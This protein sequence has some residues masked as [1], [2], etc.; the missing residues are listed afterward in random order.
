[1][2]NSNADSVASAIATASAR[3]AE[4]DMHYC[5]EKDGVLIDID[6]PDSLVA[7]ITP[8]K[9]NALKADGIINKGMIPKID[10]AFSAVSNG[11]KR[12]IIKNSDNLLNDRGTVIRN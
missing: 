8:D 6:N 10:N 12:V 7:E 2:L 9:Y 11:V 5:F 1:L 3:I 4:V